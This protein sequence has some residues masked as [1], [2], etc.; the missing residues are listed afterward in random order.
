MAAGGAAP[1]GP[2]LL[3][4]GGAHRGKLGTAADLQSAVTVTV[5]A[6]PKL[7]ATAAL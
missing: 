1:G 6:L 5:I 2:E 4:P 7:A 3:R